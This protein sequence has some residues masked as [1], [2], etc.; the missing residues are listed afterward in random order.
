MKRVII[1]LFIFIFILINVGFAE[2]QVAEENPEYRLVTKTYFL[3]HISPRDVDKILG[4]YFRRSSYSDTNS[5][6][7]VE[8]YNKNVLEFEKLLKQLDVEK[9]KILLRVFTVI[10]STQG[11]GDEIENKDLTKV[12]AELKKILS[13]KNYK[14]DGASVIAIKE[15]TRDSYIKLTSKISDLNLEI[16]NVKL[17]GDQPGKRSIEIGRLQLREFKTMLIETETSIQENGY[18]V[19]GVSKIGKDG[20]ALVLVINAE[21]H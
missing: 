12:L 14:L 1:L 18:L 17:K 16:N 9:R 20:D 19:A 8:I 10:A 13:F 11:N 5:M 21:I 15:G 6:L 2:K 4:L 3:K 7:T